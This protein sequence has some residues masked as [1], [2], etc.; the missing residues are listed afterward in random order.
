MHS[1]LAIRTANANTSAALPDPS[2]TMQG[3]LFFKA[4]R[5]VSIVPEPP[6]TTTQTIGTLVPSEK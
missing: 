6:S 1:F 4:F 3:V 5:A 2:N